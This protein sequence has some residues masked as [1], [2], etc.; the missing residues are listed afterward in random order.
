MVQPDWKSN[1]KGQQGNVCSTP[2]PC[3]Q[4]L[5]TA[6]LLFSAINH[7]HPFPQFGLLSSTISV[8]SV[9]QSTFSCYRSAL[10][11]YLDFCH[12]FQ[13]SSFTLNPLNVT[14]F[15]V[16][17]AQTGVAYPSIRSYLSGIRFM[18]IV[19]G[20]P[21]PCLSTD[22]TLRC[23]LRGIH[24]LPV[25]TQH[26]PWLLVTP[27]ILQQLHDSWSSW[28]LEHRYDTSMLWAAVC[29]GFF[30]FMWA[31]KFTCPSLQA[32]L[33]RLGYR[34]CQWTHAKPPGLSRFTCNTQ[35]MTLSVIGW[36]FAL[37]EHIS[38]LALLQRYLVTWREEGIAQVLFSCS[39]TVYIIEAE[40]GTADAAGT[41]PIW[42]WLLSLD[43]AQ[44]SDRG[45]ISSVSRR[46]WGFYDP[47]TGSLVLIGLS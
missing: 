23:V 43:R 10:N 19:Q 20:L 47:N 39:E 44:F 11:R 12:R 34:M 29:L 41:G 37:G 45:G 7:T 26:P 30:G 42:N 27:A 33:H 22:A 21:D 9:A 4:C 14:R 40:V 36:Q 13:L 16:Y 3:Y 15:V 32:F 18:Q 5:A 6:L 24:C 8:S 38:R 46:D 31:G 28:P 35:R 17:L 1:I 2:L 25:E